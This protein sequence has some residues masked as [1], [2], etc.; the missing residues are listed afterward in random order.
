M[1]GV[2]LAAAGGMYTYIVT[3]FA[4]TPSDRIHL[5]E[6]SL[7]AATIYYA[8]KIDIKTKSAYVLAWFAT[9][10]IGFVDEVIQYYLPSRAFDLNDLMINTL[11]AAVALL[12]VGF[13]VEEVE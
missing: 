3:A 4:P 10:A 13:V 11:A 12:I 8:L 2:T 5:I 9:T 6:Y 7:L 1:N